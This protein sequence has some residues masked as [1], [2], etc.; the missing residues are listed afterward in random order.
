MSIHPSEKWNRVRW[1]CDTRPC[2]ESLFLKFHL[3]D[4]SAFW[5][6]YSLRR[7]APGQ[8][9]AVGC[10]W[11]IYAGPDGTVMACDE[12][13]ASDVDCAKSRFWLRI[14]PGEL[15]TGRA[16][17]RVDRL[18]SPGKTVLPGSM[19]WD[20][21]ID[22][23]PT[24]IHLPYETMYDSFMP[25][26]KIVSPL[27][28]TRFHGTLRIQ[29]REIRVGSA[30]GMQGHNWGAA[31]SPSWAWCHVAGFE[32]EGDAAFEAVGSRLPLGPLQMPV[33]M[34][35]LRLKGQEFLLNNPARM[36]MARSN[37]KG[38][39]WQFES[40]VGRVR[41]DGT[42]VA[43]PEATVGLDYVSSDGQTVRCINSNQASA[44][45]RVRAPGIGE[46]VLQTGHAATLELGGTEAPMEIQA[47]VRG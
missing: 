25:R 28:S 14:G 26:N 20:L 2:V 29:G 40:S 42:I 7:P 4:H 36:L 1:A 34:L 9:D 46:R 39:S 15:S 33:T 6:R 13:P 5:A 8:G 19:S 41:L 37:V 10:L 24:L 18:V 3:P 11:A 44:S 45:I 12:Y 22:S 47:A 27:V 21:T 32:G 23:G 31:V 17:G 43:R 16:T 35:Y 30:P 38:L